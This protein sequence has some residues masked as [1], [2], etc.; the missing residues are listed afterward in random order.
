MAVTHS[1]GLRQKGTIEHSRLLV[2][3]GTDDQYLLTALADHLGLALHIH[4]MGGKDD[5]TTRMELLV[6]SP[7]F[8]NV[9]RLDR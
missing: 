7:G 1:G 4:Q 9:Q 8:E 6:R 3:E 2:V 5:W